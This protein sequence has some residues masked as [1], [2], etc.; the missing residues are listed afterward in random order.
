MDKITVEMSAEFMKYW[1]QSIFGRAAV[2][3]K[4][5]ELHRN[6]G[7]YFAWIGWLLKEKSLK[8]KKETSDKTKCL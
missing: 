6:T 8:E 1:K 7:L 5:A 2:A 3:T 4:D